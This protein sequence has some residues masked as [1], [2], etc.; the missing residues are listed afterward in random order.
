MG[1]GVEN[2]ICCEIRIANGLHRATDNREWYNIVLFIIKCIKRINYNII[3]S[4]ITYYI[5]YSRWFNAGEHANARANNPKT[6]G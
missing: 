2:L 5:R 1:G 6:P 3:I 4:Y